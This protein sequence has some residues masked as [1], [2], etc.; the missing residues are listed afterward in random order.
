MAGLN[1]GANHPDRAEKGGWV[2]AGIIEVFM[3]ACCL[4]IMLKAEVIIGIFT[5]ETD[6][7][8]LGS[9]FLRI[10]VVGYLMFGLVLVLQD[11][12]AVTGDTI[13]TMIVSIAMIWAIQLPL[14]FFLPGIF[15]LGVYGVRWAI[16]ASIIAGAIFYM[17]YF[18]LGRWKLK[19]V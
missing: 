11:C 5:P 15:D 17:I 1:L 16:V 19:M 12:I 10:A 2:S 14:A 8:S 4:I 18:R 13:P 9:I 3:I 7:I 6:L